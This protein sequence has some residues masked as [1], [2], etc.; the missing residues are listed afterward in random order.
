MNVVTELPRRD[1]Q[2][3]RL[4]VAFAG[5]AVVWAVAFHT[6]VMPF[7]SLVLAGGIATGVAGFWVRGA[8]DAEAVPPFGLVAR[9]A[10]LAVAVGVGHFAVGHGLFWVGELLL[11][12]ITA[13]AAS[14]YQRSSELPVWGQVLL[15][16]VL[17]AGLEEV[18]WRGA[19]TPV[20]ADRVRARLPVGSGAS[21]ATA[22]LV[23]TVGYTAFFVPTLQLA[24]IAAAALGGMV[25]G[26]LLLVTR[27][28][29]APILAHVVWT[30]LMI[31]YPPI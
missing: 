3:F 21:G 25:W 31:L 2:V 23:S 17:T 6:A 9:H 15:G 18:F 7:F 13:S 20:I 10:V 26:A 11:P 16:G 19:F 5:L 22:V 29:G 8:A 1:R 30:S 14:V 12:E 24:L 27:S 4:T 28:V